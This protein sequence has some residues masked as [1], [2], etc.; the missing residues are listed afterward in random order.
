MQCKAL[1]FMS[2]ALMI[3]RR[4]NVT[5]A[6]VPCRADK[7]TEVKTPEHGPNRLMIGSHASSRLHAIEPKRRITKLA[8]C[9]SF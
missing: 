7:G 4:C 6:G 5:K 2:R 1:M 8:T 9:F 3:D